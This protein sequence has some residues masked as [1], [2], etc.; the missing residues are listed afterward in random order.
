MNGPVIVQGAGAMGRLLASRLDRA[1]IEVELLT[2]TKS[3]VIPLSL[4]ENGSL[5]HRATMRARSVQESPTPRGSL[6]IVATKA[7]DVE[8]ALSD[9]IPFLAPGAPV[10]VISNGLGHDETLAAIAG[11]RPQLL[12]TLS[13]GAR[14]T[15][16]ADGSL[17]VH[18]L[19]DGPVEIGPSPENAADE[20]HATIAEQLCER[21]QRAGFDARAT[22]DGCSAQWR[23]AALNCGLNPVAALLGAP[24]GELPASRYF[25]WSVE[26][27]RE[28]AVLGRVSGHDLPERGWRDRLVSLCLATARNRCSMLQDLEA[29]RRLEIDHLN[30]WVAR[31]ARR[32]QVPTPRN[33]RLA[34]V[35]SDQRS[36]ELMRWRRDMREKEADL[37]L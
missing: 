20:D 1:G 21:F 12:G 3:G 26:A 25:R 6:L 13:N 11:D 36:Q 32:M 29:G 33:R 31:R 14:A 2:R 35:L 19:G 27:A 7:Y 22:E 24:N 17:E 10:L 9:G 23:K 15:E 30:G 28:T 18:A 37:T 4:Y 5:A 16:A 34:A 8:A